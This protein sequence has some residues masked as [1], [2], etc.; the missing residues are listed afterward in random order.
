MNTL[1][2][3]VFSFFGVALIPVLLWLLWR[4]VFGAG[5]NKTESVSPPS[6]SSSPSTQKWSFPKADRH[7]IGLFGEKWLETILRDNL[8][9]NVYTIFHDIMIPAKDGRTTQID[10]V[11][12]SQFG[13]FVI[14]AKHWHACIYGSRNDDFW[15]ICV[16]KKPHIR[17]DNPLNQNK[18]HIAWL[19]RTTGLNRYRMVPIHSI[20]AFSSDTTFG[21]SMPSNVLHYEDVPSFILAHSEK[22]VLS[23]HSVAEVI[24]SLRA[25]DASITP[26]QR[27]K[28]GKRRRE[29]AAEQARK[30]F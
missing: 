15:T 16:G 9:P 14:E 27:A 19:A 24:D 8:D 12:I 5:R 29:Q 21:C 10:L 17:N 4:V 26:E 13:L 2:D 7:T 1:S 6:P 25:W 23:A 28:H 18:Y 20:V 3:Y 11:V 22:A 30:G